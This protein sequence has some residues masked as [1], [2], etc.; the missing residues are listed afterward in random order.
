MGAIMASRPH[1]VKVTRGQALPILVALLL[2]ASGIALVS[3]RDGGATLGNVGLAS[4]TAVF[5]VPAGAHAAGANGA[6]WRTDLE[7]HNAGAAAVSYTVELLKRDSANATPE[8]RAFSL[9]P[10]QSVRYA[11]VLWGMFSYTGA[12][13]LRA[14]A[15][16]EQVVVT[17][18]TYN[19]IGTNPWGLPEGSS[20]GQ[21][22]PGI[23]ES[24][25]IS[26]GEEGRLIQLT[27]RE[28]TS[29]QEFRT[30]VALLN[31][32]GGVVDVKVDLY[33][34]DGTYLGTK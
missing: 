14:T 31:V 33:R 6:N 26:Y 23:S 5:Y 4:G 10:Q 28:A 18:R 32:T 2:A 12:G 24:Q 13:A 8:S 11:D 21:F 20:F 16:S 27:Q 15:S 22:V 29:L 1:D 9:G 34:A 17:S 25:A 19:L 3:I 30:N 7:V